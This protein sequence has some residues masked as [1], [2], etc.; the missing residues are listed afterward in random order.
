[1][2]I[3]TKKKVFIFVKYL[4]CFSAKKKAEKGQLYTTEFR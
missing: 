1:M 4:A 2:L 3:K